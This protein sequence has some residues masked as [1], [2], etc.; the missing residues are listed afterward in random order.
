VYQLR[1]LQSMVLH[2]FA[3]YGGLAAVPLERCKSPTQ[4]IKPH[5]YKIKL[6]WSFIRITV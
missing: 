3:F 4:C 6:D 2:R 1:L 5:P